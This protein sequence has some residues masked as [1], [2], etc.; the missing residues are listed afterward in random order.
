[1]FETKESNTTKVEVEM[2]THRYKYETDAK[3]FTEV[4]LA[5][6]KSRRFIFSP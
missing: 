3:M 2:E 6:K 1:M 5:S 4:F